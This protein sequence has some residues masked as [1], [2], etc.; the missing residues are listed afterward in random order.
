MITS[1]IGKTFLKAFN[2]KNQSNLSAK[3][4]FDTEYFKLFFDHPKYLQWV[5]NSPFVQMKSGQKPHL[6]TPEERAEKLE[7]LHDKVANEAPDA[8]FALG[9]PASEEK[10]F[11]STS[12]LITDISTAYNEEDIYCSWLGSSLGIGVAGGYNLLIDDAELLL[13]IFDGWKFYRQYL[14][15]PTLEQLRGNQINS[16][17]G[18]WL[19][20]RLGKSYREDFTFSNLEDEEIFSTKENLIEVDT[21]DWARLFFS[22]SREYPDRK[23]MTYIYSFGQTNK[24]VG[25]I[26]LY[27]KSGTR[28]KEIYKHL[29]QNDERFDQKEFQ[30]LYGR[31]I[32][33]ACELGSIG[34]QA[35]R[36]KNLEKYLKEAKNFALNKEEDI[37]TYQS[38]K[39]WL[40]AMLS[41]NKQE[42]TDY[43]SELANLILRYR[44]G[45]SG[46]ERKNLIEKGL[47]A[48]RSKKPFIEALT[49]MIAGVE[50]E[51]LAQLK[52][53][54]NEVHL[55]TNEEFVYFNTL[56]KFDYTFVEKN[57]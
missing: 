46:T 1:I 20:Y 23:L 38:Y 32:K 47:L 14:N 27:L 53:L 31:H 39:T 2:E 44:K 52:A 43:T 16:W 5:T 11:A 50:Q 26:P 55:M 35:L 33:R 21:V 34:L 19:T 57:L 25:F 4:F 9:Y 22:L 45:A 18:Q 37:I 30:S 29:Y 10:E 3:E 13:L 8:S 7:A 15:D 36:P 24:T 56:L 54:K 42:I 28:L 49:E 17:N 41:R 48:A 51:D 40:I 6:L 12:G